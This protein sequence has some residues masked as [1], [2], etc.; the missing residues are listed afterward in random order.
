MT[1][2]GFDLTHF[3]SDVNFKKVLQKFKLKKYIRK[4]NVVHYDQGDIISGTHAWS[5]AEP[6]H[7]EHFDYSWTNPKTKLKIVTSNNAIT[8]AF[9]SPKQRKKE[10]GYASY[11]GIE[12]NKADVIKLKNMI[13]RM[14]SSK[15]ESPYRR[16][17]I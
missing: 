13:K 6:Y 4:K 16:D 8:G 14:A 2:W 11:V 15:D 9:S 12:G 5:K 7:A 10:K 3:G 1:K 17:F